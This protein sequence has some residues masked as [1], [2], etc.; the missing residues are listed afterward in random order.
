MRYL[1]SLLMILAAPHAGAKND[2]YRE[3]QSSE[4][5]NCDCGSCTCEGHES[6][7]YTKQIRDETT[8][9][10]SIT[11]MAYTC[12]SNEKLIDAD[13]KVMVLKK[14]KTPALEKFL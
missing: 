13:V 9:E 10:V 2:Q 1:L 11:V 6:G 4:P 5:V 14:T 3:G 12:D 8:T 7:A